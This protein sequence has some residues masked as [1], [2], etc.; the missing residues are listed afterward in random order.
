[1]YTDVTNGDILTLKQKH[2]HLVT[3][4]I[5]H[6]YRMIW[7]EISTILCGKVHHIWR[8]FSSFCLR[9]NFPPFAIFKMMV[10]G[11][12]LN[13]MRI[14]CAPAFT[15]PRH[16]AVNNDVSAIRMHACG[17]SLRINFEISE[18]R[19]TRSFEVKMDVLQPHVAAMCQSEHRHLAMK[20]ERCIV[21][22][23]G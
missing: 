1:M 11:I 23:N 20:H 2:S 22:F 15:Y 4:N 9:K 7:L 17:H 12:V 5:A 8:Q 18:F 19:T 3:N 21:S 14:V 16:S 10:L 6:R 13:A